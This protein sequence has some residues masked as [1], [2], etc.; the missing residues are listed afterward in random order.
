[1]LS[2][3]IA[4]F[5]FAPLMALIF[6]GVP[7]AFAL[8]SVALVF[9]IWEFGDAAVHLFVAKVQEITSSHVLAAAPLFVFMGA[10][11]ERS[12]TA[13][14]L[15]EAIHM[16]TRRLPGGLA[17]GTIA[18]CVLFAASS[19]VVGATETVV[20]MLA[21]PVMLRYGYDKALISGTICAGG[22][23]GSII[24]PSVLVV[25][26]SLIAEIG[27]GDMFAG[28]LFPGLMLAGC[29]VL[30]ILIRCTLDPNSGPRLPPSD[31]DPSLAE[32]LRITA[33]A[34]LPPVVLIFVVL[35]TIIAGMAVPTEAASMGA[36]GAVVLT[37]IYRNFTFSVLREAILKT[38]SITAMILTILLAGTMFS[39]VFVGIGG[40]L[41]A[42]RAIEVME[43]GSWGTLLL[44]LA[45]T[46]LAGFVMDVLSIILIVVPVAVPLITGFGFDIIWFFILL[47][48][49]LQTSLLTPPMAG[50]IFYLRAIAPPEI[51]LRDM[52]RGMTPFILLHFVVLALV[53]V[54]P[55]LALWLPDKL[56]G[57]N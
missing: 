5:M 20:G 11:L 25:I 10:M 38:I 52:Y 14:R 32:K 34:L 12:G 7:V 40:L 50:A 6:L 54:F 24:P 29:Y 3:D 16:W 18:M 36:V 42:E 45:L 33:V 44:I 35:G 17:V 43:F 23:L 2:I 56:L 46:F 30:Y 47:L 53:M 41:A 55:E 26:L 15:F 39:S 13:E 51:T 28:M 22:S 27:I 49:T 4:L 37:V 31:D 21:I 57:F 8:M 19:G 9:G 48:I 1:M